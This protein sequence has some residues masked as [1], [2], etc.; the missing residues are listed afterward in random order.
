[1]VGAGRLQDG[2]DLQPGRDPRVDSPG[3]RPHAAKAA[4]VLVEK[5]FASWKGK[6]PA[7]KSFPAPPKRSGRTLALVDRPGSVQ[8]R[9]DIGTIAPNEKDPV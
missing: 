5:A 1:M 8:A 4:R 6:A 3:E 2:L 7:A 9:I